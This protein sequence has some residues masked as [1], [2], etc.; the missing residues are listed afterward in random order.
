MSFM[1]VFRYY[2]GMIPARRKA[3][4]HRYNNINTSNHT[5]QHSY[6]HSYL[7]VFSK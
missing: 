7:C 4:L 3:T 6:H 5:N 2:K 1:S